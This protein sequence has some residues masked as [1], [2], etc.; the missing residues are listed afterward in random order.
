MD[1]N[2]PQQYIDAWNAHSGDQVVGFMTPDVEFVDTTLGEQFTGHE[3]IRKFVESMVETLATDYRFELTNAFTTDTDYAAEWDMIG[4]QD[5]SDGRLPVTNKPFRV[6]GVSVGKL[7]NGK[8]AVNRD[9]WNMA[10]FLTQIGLM[11][12]Q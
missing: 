1:K 4:T 9:Y 6:H 3:E 5:R 11:P 10:D 7:R 2:W 12:A 8:I